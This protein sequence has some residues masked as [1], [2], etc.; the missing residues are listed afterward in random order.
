MVKAQGGDT[1]AV[2]DPGRL[3]QSKVRVAVAAPRAG[4]VS[5]IDALALGKL[6]IE[7]GAGRTRADQ[8]IDPA[9]G[10]VLGTTVGARV[11][12]AE[13][14][15]TIHAATRGLAKHVRARVAEAF[16]VGSRRPRQRPLVLDRLR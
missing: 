4:Y 3:P 1:R 7:L 9:A 15:I 8:A 2:D 11:A 16:S 14:L 5:A 6:A 12:K 10:F 13:T